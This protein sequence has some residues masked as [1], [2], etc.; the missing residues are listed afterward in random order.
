M[1]DN[2]RLVLESNHTL[3]D[4]NLLPTL[5][6][7]YRHLSV[8]SLLSRDIDSISAALNCQ[9]TPVETISAPI[10]YKYTHN[11]CKSQALFDTTLYTTARSIIIMAI[12]VQVGLYIFMC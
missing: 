3:Q 7:N 2:H 6:A 4:A 11:S 12:S 5:Q 8:V 1:V 9:I 10:F